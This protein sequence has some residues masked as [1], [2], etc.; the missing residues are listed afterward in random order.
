MTGRG[1]NLSCLDESNTLFI[2]I[3]VFVCNLVR[4]KSST[5]SLFVSKVV[6]LL[7]YYYQVHLIIDGSDQMSSTSP[8]AMSCSTME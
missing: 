5:C 4:F 7:K 6:Y 8:L 3:N 2:Q 1:I